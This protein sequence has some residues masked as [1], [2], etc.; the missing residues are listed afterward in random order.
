MTLGIAFAVVMSAALD[1]CE[2][3]TL[4][5]ASPLDEAS[6]TRREDPSN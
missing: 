1:S 4:S 6:A 3:A 5:R 2:G